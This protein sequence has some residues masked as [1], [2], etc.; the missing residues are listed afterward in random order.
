MCMI[1]M[2]KTALAQPRSEDEP[3]NG[4]GLHGTGTRSAT[5]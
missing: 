5:R 4:A 1:V 2:K 3:D